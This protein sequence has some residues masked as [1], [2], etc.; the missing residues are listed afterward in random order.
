MDEKQNYSYL[1]VGDHIIMD[2]VEL[3]VCLGDN[4]QF[5]CVRCYLRGDSRCSSLSCFGS[6]FLGADGFYFKKVM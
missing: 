3:E 6:L 5:D 2:G 1:S 4:S